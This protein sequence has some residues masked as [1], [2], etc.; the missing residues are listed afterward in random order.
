MQS[1][2]DL[3]YSFLQIHA[4]FTFN[5]EGVPT[6]KV[7][8]RVKISH[9]FV[10]RWR[11]VTQI[12]L[13]GTPAKF[14]N[15]QHHAGTVVS[16]AALNLHSI[17]DHLHSIPDN[18]HSTPDSNIAA[19]DT[20][21]RDHPSIRGQE[22]DLKLKKEEDYD[23]GHSSGSIAEE[24]L[25]R[26]GEWGGAAAA[27]G[28]GRGGHGAEETQQIHILIYS[29]LHKDKNKLDCASQ[30]SQGYEGDV[31]GSGSRSSHQLVGS[32]EAGAR[33]KRPSIEAEET[34]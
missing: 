26:G 23:R 5:D 21:E 13:D 17:P 18:L 29:M 10:S 16:L 20:R 9:S 27:G 7:H 30:S 11:Y 28:G 15:W 22:Q 6:V 2:T 8:T 32:T 31:N 24:R 25:P 12:R 19:W 34:Y 4:H 14:E 3:L 1:L 33:Q